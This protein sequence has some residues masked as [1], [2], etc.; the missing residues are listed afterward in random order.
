MKKKSVESKN[1]RGSKSGRREE[2]ETR[3][4][5]MKMEKDEKMER[6]EKEGE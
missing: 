6:R 5:W 1:I 3:E 2:E 4:W